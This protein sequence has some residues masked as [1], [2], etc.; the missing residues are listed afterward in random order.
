MR[1]VEEEIFDA[2]TMFGDVE[3]VEIVKELTTMHVAID[4]TAMKVTHEAYVLFRN[5]ED[6]YRALKSEIYPKNIVNL[7]PADTWHQP[8]YKSLENQ[9]MKGVLVCNHHCKMQSVT[10]NF[11]NLSIDRSELVC[12]HTVFEFELEMKGGTTLNEVRHQL[13]QLMPNV[14]HLMLN[15]FSDFDKAVDEEMAIG[16]GDFQRRVMEVIGMNALGPKLDSL[17][18]DGIA[19]ISTMMLKCLATVLKKVRVLKLDTRYCNILYLLPKFCPNLNELVLI[20]SQWDG[21]GADEPVQ[22]WPTLQTLIMK[23]ITLDVDSDTACGKRF[24]RFISLNPQLETLEMDL[25]VDN[26]LLKVICKTARRLKT[27]TM[28]RVNYESVGGMIDQ[29]V[30]L[31]HLASIMVNTLI[32]KT[33]DFKSMLSCVECL[34]KKRR[35]QMSTL[36]QNYVLDEDDPM[37]IGVNFPLKYHDNCIC[38]GPDHRAISFGN[39]SD[40]INLSK[41]KPSIAIVVNVAR[42]LKD[43]DKTLQSRIFTMFRN[44][45][46]F[47]P[48]VLKSTV[49]EEPDRFVY[50]HVSSIL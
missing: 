38:H 45:K 37:M 8:D 40:V 33:N 29:L 36:L 17:S 7:V 2:F 43:A 10:R 14:G 13:K 6:A 28:A 5:S 19:G 20:G 18:I 50:L 11:D 42:H 25:V 23:N 27:L 30:R 46:K 32:F 1:N 39:Q 35:L 49:L 26:A 9:P 3:N 24:R 44:T 12:D 31:K 48:N 4:D 41:D 16:K 22:T 47:Y 34:S 15:L 21:D